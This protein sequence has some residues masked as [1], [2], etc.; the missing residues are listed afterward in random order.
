MTESGRLFR[1][2]AIS[3][4]GRCSA[5]RSHYFLPGSHHTQAM[6]HRKQID[7]LQFYAFM[8]V[9]LVHSD[10]TQCW[11][12]GYRVSLLLVISCF[13]ITIVLIKFESRPRKQTIRSLYGFRA[14]QICPAHC[15]VLTQLLP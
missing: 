9:I 6:K 10:V 2:T 13:L 14:L 4:T 5:Q 1:N 8:F 3:H 12:D 15:L 7:G 11:W